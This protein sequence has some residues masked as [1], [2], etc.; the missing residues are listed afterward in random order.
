MEE[1]TTKRMVLFE[2]HRLQT[3]QT[4]WDYFCPSCRKMTEKV[5]HARP[6]RNCGVELLPYSPTLE[7]QLRMREK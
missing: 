5:V 6:C 1:K 3:G 4:V 2:A 7:E